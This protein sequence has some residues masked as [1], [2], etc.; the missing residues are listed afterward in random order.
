M[1]RQFEAAGADIIELNMCCPNMS[2]NIEMTG[3]EEHQVRES[4][5][6][7]GQHEDISAEIVGAIG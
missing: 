2:Y 3:D 5:G 6:S 1:A 4:R 7:M